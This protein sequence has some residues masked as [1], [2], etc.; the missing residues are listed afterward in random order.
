MEHW[1]AEASALERAGSYAII[2]VKNGR[3]AEE[4]QLNGQRAVIPQTQSELQ[5]L[6]SARAREDAINWIQQQDQL[7]C[8]DG[9]TLSGGSNDGDTWFMLSSLLSTIASWLGNGADFAEPCGPYN[10]LRL[11][12]AWSMM[13]ERQGARYAAGLHTVRQEMDLLR[14]HG[15]PPWLQSV[16]LPAKTAAATAILNLDDAAN[17][18]VLLH[19]T[20]PDFLLS[21]LSQVRSAM[22][23]SPH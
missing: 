21:I 5:Q 7:L 19:G 1:R 4:V 6:Q 3:A 9:F 22:F 11:V 18:T 10:N 14:S 15:V 8:S 13:H 20:S 2:G 16:G 12:A 23:C 17:E